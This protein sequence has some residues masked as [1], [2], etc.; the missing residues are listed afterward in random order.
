M[1]ILVM[2]TLALITPLYI[3]YE[4]IETD[5][6]FCVS[7]HLM[8]KPFEL[9]RSSAMHTVTCHSCHEQSTQDSLN[10]VYQFYVL[11]KQNIT[12]HAE[13]P[14]EKC[15]ACHK[16]GDP[17]W[18]QIS[19]EVGHKIHQEKG[20]ITCLQ[21]HSKSLHQFTPPSE[22]C[23]DCH[24][25]T[26]QIP[27]M[28]IHCT[29]CHQYT[30]KGKETLTPQRLECMSCHATRGNVTMS[31]PEKAHLD[32]Q[33]STCHQPHNQSKPIGCTTCHETKDL[34]ILH[35]DAIHSKLTCQSCHIPHR[36]EDVRT[37]C[38]DCHADKT[39]HN[40]PNQCND[41]HIFKKIAT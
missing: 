16:S 24:K 26:V 8:Q 40:T 38:T 41:C 10:L 37:T 33:C 6:T 22:L 18:R 27:E 1:I 14:Q 3:T 4:Y 34:P 17:M 30:A 28:Q 20:N 23:S 21:C 29:S 19:E 15:E 12:K 32:T 11:N 13:V 39:K 31:V 5:P 25:Q 2:A 7:C 36:V 9:W 35:R